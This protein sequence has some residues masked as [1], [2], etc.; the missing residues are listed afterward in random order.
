[1]SFLISVALA[2]IGLC[3]VVSIAAVVLVGLRELVVGVILAPVKLYD[4]VREAPAR[5]AA[6][7]AAERWTWKELALIPAVFIG[8]MALPFIIGPVL[9][10]FGVK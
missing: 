9:A 2:F 6:R 3:V 10:L 5:R 4:F 7:P 8:A 1:M